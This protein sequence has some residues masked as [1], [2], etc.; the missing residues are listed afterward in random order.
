MVNGAATIAV[1]WTPVSAWTLSAWSSTAG[2]RAA[3]RRPPPSTGR[4]RAHRL[5]RGPRGT[6]ARGRRRPRTR[7]PGPVGRARR[8]STRAACGS[9]LIRAA[10]TL[11]RSRFAVVVAHDDPRLAAVSE[12]D[13]ENLAAVRGWSGRPRFGGSVGPAQRGRRSARHR[14]ATQPRIRVRTRSSRSGWCPST[15][16]DA[17]SWQGIY[18]R[19]ARSGR[20]QNAART[21]A[22][23]A[24]ADGGIGCAASRGPRSSGDRASAS[25]AKVAGSESCRG[26]DKSLPTPPTVISRRFVQAQPQPIEGIGGENTRACGDR[27][28][29]QAGQP[30][31]GWAHRS[32]SPW[33]KR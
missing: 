12:I 19:R 14:V 25:G 26:T 8:R 20:V 5:R 30:S 24:T 9:P 22:L 7:P 29:E 1:V 33:R 18:T 16:S 11:S 10:I 15:G 27:D 13:R 23:R 6:T 3:P 17:G 28:G 2:P 31:S 4:E 21:S 32:R